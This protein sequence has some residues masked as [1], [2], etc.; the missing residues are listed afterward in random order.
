MDLSGIA[1]QICLAK[2]HGFVWQINIDMSGKSTWICL[3]PNHIE[4]FYSTSEQ[5]IVFYSE[6]KVKKMKRE[7][8]ALLETSDRNLSLYDMI[9]F[10]G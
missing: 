2:Q 3:G 4:L 1:G 7:E 8:K 5:L 9:Y 10:Q 6:E